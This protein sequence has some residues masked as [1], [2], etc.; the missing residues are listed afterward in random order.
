[1]EGLRNTHPQRGLSQV[2]HVS[3]LTVGTLSAGDGKL[4]LDSGPEDWTSGANC[5][6]IVG[7]SFLEAK[8]KRMLP[9]AKEVCKGCSVRTKCED[10]ATRLGKMGVWGGKT[11]RERQRTV[12]RDALGKAAA[13]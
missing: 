8:S 10:Y 2:G 11:R 4:I 3:E 6:G 7:K 5:L 13:Q 1:M 9:Q 12:R